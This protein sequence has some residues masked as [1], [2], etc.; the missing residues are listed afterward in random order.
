MNRVCVNTHLGTMGELMFSDTRVGEWKIVTLKLCYLSDN[1]TC[2]HSQV[3][4]TVAS[5]VP[6]SESDLIFSTFTDEYN[7]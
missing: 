5:F 6:N 2:M 1:T 3:L 7:L 4:L